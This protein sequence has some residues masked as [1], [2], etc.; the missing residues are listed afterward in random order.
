MPQSPPARTTNFKT[1]A[2]PNIILFLIICL[3]K[4]GF[5]LQESH[6]VINLF[7]QIELINT[8]L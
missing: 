8:I 6:S 4:K 5:V 7:E 2:G 3:K 1:P